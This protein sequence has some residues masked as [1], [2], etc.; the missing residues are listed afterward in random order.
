MFDKDVRK[1][2]AYLDDVLE[3]GLALLPL[4][5]QKESVA[6]YRQVGLGIMGLADALI[7]MSIRYGSK[8]SL[9]I[10]EKIAKV[11]INAALQESAIRARDLGTYPAYK[12]EYVLKSPYLLAV[13][14]PET[15]DLIEKYGL[16][17]A[18]VLSIAPTGSISTMIGVSGGIEPIFQI[19]YTRESKTLNEDG[20]TFYKVYTPIAK[21]Y[22]EENNITK[23]E[24]LPD[25]FVTSATL[26]YRERVDMQAV[27]QKYIDAAISST[28]NVP[29]D[30]TVEQ[31][32]DMYIYAWE[33]GLKGITLFRDGGAR[34]GI[35][36][37]EK[38]HK[39]EVE[40]TVKQAPPVLK[41]PH[42]KHVCPECGGKMMVS[43]NCEECQDCG[44]SP[45]AI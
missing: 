14:T 12:K 3:E 16:R 39:E 15:L 25:F 23:E 36:T 35:L 21:E 28:V 10:S 1:G 29:Y 4:E 44:Y 33:K 9:I 2:I 42:D 18:E 40:D 22:M 30:F 19:S 20:P 45:C 31:V 6:K 5:E 13:A 11:M 26:N 17:N 7:M 37:T 41:N 43:G 38:D 24:D 34:T 8:D 32:E 27:W